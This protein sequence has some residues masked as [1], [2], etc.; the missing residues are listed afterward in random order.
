MR[1]ARP[2]SKSRT[3]SY[4]RGCAPL[5]DRR[6]AAE[7]DRATAPRCRCRARRPAHPNIREEKRGERVITMPPSDDEQMTALEA[8]GKGGAVGGAG[9][10]RAYLAAGNALESELLFQLLAR[11]LAR[12]D[13][14][15]DLAPLWCDVVGGGEAVEAAHR[16]SLRFVMT[17]SYALG[18]P[19]RREA[20]HSTTRRRRII[21]RTRHAGARVRNQPGLIRSAMQQRVGTIHDVTSRYNPMMRSRMARPYRACP[22]RLCRAF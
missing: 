18:P 19:A 12:D 11:L 15:V 6:I 17:V 7:E 14:E 4:H 9:R 5:S 2:S 10:V 22:S 20:K 3:R 8:S 21:R 1:H 16:Y 13:L